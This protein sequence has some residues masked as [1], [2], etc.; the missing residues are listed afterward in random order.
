MNPVRKWLCHNDN[1]ADFWDNEAGKRWNP[2]QGEWNLVLRQEYKGNTFFFVQK[3]RNQ[4]NAS[5]IPAPTGV[6][7]RVPCNILKTLGNEV[8][9]PRAIS[10][11]AAIPYYR[12]QYL[13][14]RTFTVTIGDLSIMV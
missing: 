14:R 6:P 12:V 5:L 3:G 7:G 13:Q 1:P 4:K 11:S 10:V 2:F 8:I 9:R